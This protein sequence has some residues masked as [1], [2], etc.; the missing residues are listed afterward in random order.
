MTTLILACDVQPSTHLL[1]LLLP[2]TP[3]PRSPETLVQ[4]L[5]WPVFHCP[6]GGIGAAAK[7][8][9]SSGCLS[10]AN[11][12]YFRLRWFRIMEMVTNI[13]TLLAKQVSLIVVLV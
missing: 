2:P 7:L 13:N 12:F 3:L 9:E 6:E 11:L 5:T 8:E 1:P 4:G 10:S